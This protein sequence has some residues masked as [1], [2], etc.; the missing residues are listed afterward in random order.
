MNASP[1]SRVGH[2]EAERADAEEAVDAGRDQHR[3]HQRGDAARRRRVRLGQPDVQR[4]DA[5]LHAEADEEEDEQRVAH[6]PGHDV[7][8]EQRRERRASRPPPP[9]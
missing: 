8:G 7:A 2:A 5:G 6:R 1:Q 4:D 3:R 9:G